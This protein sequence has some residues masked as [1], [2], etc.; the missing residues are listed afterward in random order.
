[1]NEAYLKSDKTSK[2]DETY[3]PFYGVEPIIKYLSKDNVIWCPFDEEWSAFPRRLKECGFDVISSH[4]K[5]EYDFFKI[6]PPG[7]TMI[8][9]NPPYSI[10]DKVIKRCYELNKPFA[11]LMPITTLQ[12]ERRYKI[13]GDSIQ[14]LTFD[15]RINYHTRGNLKTTSNACHFG[16]AYF[17][18]DILPEKLIIEELNR[19]DR[20]LINI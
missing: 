11:L 20:P 13:W 4:I 19:F 12:G 7:W 10:K 8:V 1:M 2:G 5:D 9:S 15:K 6:E 3:T 17:C 18:K 14:V 16:S